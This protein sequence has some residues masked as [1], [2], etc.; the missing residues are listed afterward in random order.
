MN[1][2]R[3]QFS[4]NNTSFYV[5]ACSMLL[6]ITSCSKSFLDVAPQAQTPGQAFWK[7]QQDATKAVNAMYANLREWNNIAFAPIAVESMPSDDAEK[8]STPGDATFMNDYDNFT[9]SSTT[10]Q[11]DGFWAGQYQTINFAN[12]V[13]DNVDT[14]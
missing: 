9:V 8:G 13:I 4:I 7:T 6:G 2:K 11:L 5:L 1:K 3:K 10:S 14:M 12:Q